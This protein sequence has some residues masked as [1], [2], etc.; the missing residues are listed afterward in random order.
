MTSRLE[1]KFSSKPSHGTYARGCHC[2]DC[3]R[4]HRTYMSGWRRAQGIKPMR[5]A[6]HGTYYY[7]RKFG[8]TCS[9]CTKAVK[10]KQ[11]ADVKRRRDKML[12]AREKAGSTKV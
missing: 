12:A 6:K 4:E 1:H 3:K 7:A 9:R 8:C 2:E 5:P 10:A 11:N